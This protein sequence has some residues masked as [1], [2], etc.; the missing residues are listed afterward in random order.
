M[1]FPQ[2]VPTARSFEPGSWPVK[3]YRSQNGS[4]VRILYG[5]RETEAKMSLTYSNVADSVA[6][7]FLLHYRSVKGTFQ[8]FDLGGSNG[9]YGAKRGWQGD[10][11]ALAAPYAAK[12]RY[13]GPPKV[14]SVRPGVSTV[15]VDLIAV[16]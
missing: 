12:W 9:D 1:T 14:A 5:D 6:D 2:H 16:I 4:E 8:L 7:D 3:T 10:P 15:Q 11:G 13:E